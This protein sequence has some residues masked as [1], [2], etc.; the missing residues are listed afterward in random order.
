MLRRVL[1]GP[2]IS[3]AAIGAAFINARLSHAV[4]LTIPFFHLS[5]RTVDSHWPEVVGKGGAESD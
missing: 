5:H 4:F 3:L 2:V 1:T